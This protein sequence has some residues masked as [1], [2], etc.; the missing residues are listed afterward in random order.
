MVACSPRAHEGARRRREGRRHGGGGGEKG[1]GT[2]A[3]PLVKRVLEAEDL[4]RSARK[5]KEATAKE[6]DA[7]REILGKLGAR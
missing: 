2:A 4:L 5:S 7:V 1:G 6:L 3:A